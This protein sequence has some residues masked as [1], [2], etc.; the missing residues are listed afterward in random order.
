MLT[1]AAR[2][3]LPHGRFPPPPPAITRVTPTSV[4]V[5]GGWQVVVRG[6]DLTHVTRVLFGD[7]PAPTFTSVTARELNAVAPP[8]SAG[9]VNIRVITPHGVSRKTHA[10]VVHFVALQ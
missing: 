3:L 9:A 10:D 5:R 2:L 6:T 1:H 8:H 4:P 7:R